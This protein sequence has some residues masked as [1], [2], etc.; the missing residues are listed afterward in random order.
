MSRPPV[1]WE[2]RM[3]LR[4]EERPDP[5]VVIAA[6]IRQTWTKRHEHRAKLV[7]VPGGKEGR[8]A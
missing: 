3:A 2:Q 1:P 4:V 5:V 6:V 7:V 8:A